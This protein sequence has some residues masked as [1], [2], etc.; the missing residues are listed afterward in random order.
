MTLIC[1]A[2]SNCDPKY[3]ALARSIWEE[4]FVVYPGDPPPQELLKKEKEQI[5]RAVKALAT[6]ARAR[7]AR[8]VRAA[9]K[10]WPVPAIRG[11]LL[12]A[13]ARLG[14]IA[15]PRLGAPGLYFADYP[16]LRGYY[17]PEWS[18]LT[19]V[20]AERFTAA[21]YRIIQRDFWAPEAPAAS[22]K[23]PPPH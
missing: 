5:V 18:H 11:A 13:H 16:E 7:R 15:R 2:R 12:S 23:A 6:A 20:E 21:I 8:A 22:D 1:G 4:G 3:R 19:R 17:L 10:R 9:A 14:R